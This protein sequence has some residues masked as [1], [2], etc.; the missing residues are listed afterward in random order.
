MPKR[1]TAP[2]QWQLMRL[3]HA[4]FNAFALVVAVAR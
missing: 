1:L 3:L 4:S 2:I